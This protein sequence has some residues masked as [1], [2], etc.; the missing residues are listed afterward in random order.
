MHPVTQYALECVERTR[1][2]G[3]PERMAA[4]RHLRDLARAGQLDK[5]TAART[6]KATETTLP[7]KEPQ[8]LFQFDEAKADR[9]YN[10]FT[11]CKHVEGPLAGKPL[12]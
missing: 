4:L 12:S 3:N 8:F 1:T 11:H 7:E 9:I 2:V 6:A 10:W 5:D